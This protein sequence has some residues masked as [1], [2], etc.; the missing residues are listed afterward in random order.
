M[1]QNTNHWSTRHLFPYNSQQKRKF[2]A[3]DHGESLDIMQKLLFFE[4]KIYENVSEKSFSQF[5][6]M[7]GGGLIGYNHLLSH[8][9]R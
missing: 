7:L 1:I 4:Q 3:D 8:K 2:V 6:K 9:L 5:S